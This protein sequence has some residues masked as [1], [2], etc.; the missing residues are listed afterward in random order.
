MSY[1]DKFKLTGKTAV[2]C[3]G[4]GLIGKQVSTAFIQA[5]AKVIVLDVDEA[6]GKQFSAES[7][8]A[9]ERFDLSDVT[10]LDEAIASLFKRHS[11]I[12]IWV[13]VAYPRTSDWGHG[14]EDVPAESWQR[15]VDMHMNSYCIATRAACEEMRKAK[16]DG[17]V[18]NFG[19]TYGVVGPDF[20][21]YGGTDMKNESTYAAIKGGIVNFCRYAASYYGKYNIRVNCLCPGGMYD[22]QEASFVKAYSLRTPLRRMGKPEEVASAALF[23][24]SDASSYITGTTFMVDGGWTCI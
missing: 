23:L 19:S 21:I 18:I 20:E 22:N 15:N 4:L 17:R 13:N 12:Q 11:Q 2:V 16:I 24:A 6:K 3:G 10:H 14:I 5:G 9:F 1:L 7:G 8:A